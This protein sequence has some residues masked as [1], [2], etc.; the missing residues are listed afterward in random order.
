VLALLDQDTTGF[1][2]AYSN[3]LELGVLLP[4]VT[5][6]P[7]VI[8]ETWML[9]AV[10]R[11][12]EPELAA[13][14][15][16]LTSH[17]AGYHMY[18]AI[19]RP[20]RANEILSRRERAA[21]GFY[22]EM[23]L[24]DATYGALP[25]EFGLA[26]AQAH[27]EQLA[28]KAVGEFT[29]DDVRSLVRLTLWRLS[30]GDTSESATT[31]DMLRA[32]A[33]GASRIDALSYEVAA[34]FLEADL[35]ERRGD[36]TA[37]AT[38]ERMRGDYDAGVSLGVSVEAGL[39]FA[40]ADL[41]ERLGEPVEALAILERQ[42]VMSLNN[43]LGAEYLRERGRLSALLGDNERAIREYG[44]YL[45]LRHDPEPELEQEVEDVRRALAE[46]TGSN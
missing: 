29:D 3:A 43:P 45:L 26:A 4:L 38:L 15:A 16:G 39:H 7:G 24:T 35:A 37:S 25:E 44:H 46:I 5:A 2:G 10:E 28:G 32:A 22:H 19:G 14:D 23:R 21:G 20:Q 9:E 31:I 33:R 27:E 12:I 30:R 40:L 18:L 42:R 1:A 13:V 6:F 11:S 34:L 41:Y 17:R 8:S 36:A